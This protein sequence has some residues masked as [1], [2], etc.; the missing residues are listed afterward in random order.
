MVIK[1]IVGAAC[2]CLTVV[3]INANAVDYQIIDLGTLGGMNS[4]GLGI[5]NSGQVTGD[6][7]TADNSANHAFISNG[8]SMEDLGTLG[9]I[10]SHGLGINN[11]G[12]VTG[13]SDTVYF[14]DKRAFIYDDGNMVDIGTLGGGESFGWSINDSGVVTGY[15]A[16]A[17]GVTHAFVYDN[18]SMM[19]LGTLGGRTSYGRDINSSGQVTGSGELT[20]YTDFHAFIYDDGSMLDLGTLGGGNSSGWGINS[21]GQVIGQSQTSNDSSYH[22]FF[23]DGSIMLDLGTLGG[24]ASY[25]RGINDSG[26]MVGLSDNASNNRSAFYYDGSTMLDLCLVTDC[27][28]FGWTGFTEAWDI[29]DNGDIIGIGSIDGQYHAFL[30]TVSTVPIPVII[31][32]KPSKKPENVIDFK[33]DKNL[34]IAIVG[35]EAFDALQVDPTTVKFGTNE[36]SPVRCIGQDYNRDGF[37]DLILTFKLN[38]TGI[39]CGD[40]EATLTGE[41]YDKEAIEGSDNFTVEP[42]P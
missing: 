29:N 16:T 9:G 35:E 24:R 11:S 30:V 5:N 13:Y 22:A 6:S 19:D 10:S 15:S 26:Q 42:C 18:G 40:T 3:S 39:S 33:K 20:N 28:S 34:K 21:S 8:N 27:T 38:Q 4:R 36:A 41:T 14:S 32:I 25:G 7:N 1:S 31:D 2:A 37:P 12:Q 23:Y 17:D